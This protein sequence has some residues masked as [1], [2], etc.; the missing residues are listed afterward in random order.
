MTEQL[1]NRP[2][3]RA[4]VQQMRGEGVP[5]GVTSEA[6]ADSRPSSGLAHGTLQD[7]LVQV[8][9]TPLACRGVPVGARGRKDPVPC[10]LPACS[11]S[12]ALERVRQL[13]PTRSAFEVA[14]VLAPHGLKLLG[15][16]FSHGDRQQGDPIAVALAAAVCAS[17]YTFTWV[18]SMGSWPWSP[19][20]HPPE[21]SSAP[22]HNRGRPYPAPRPPL[23]RRREGRARHPRR[24][25]LHRGAPG[26]LLQGRAAGLGRAVDPRGVIRAGGRTRCW[27]RDVCSQTPQPLVPVSPPC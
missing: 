23:G 4:V 24:G 27:G 2:D 17:R 15:H 25:A 11:R 3:V 26:P 8:M 7:R 9:P 16:G 21:G 10:Q 5:E 13:D 1:L 19:S 6:L 20:H 22:P 12:L 18:G 14:L